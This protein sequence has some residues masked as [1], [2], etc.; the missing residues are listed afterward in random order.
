M[1]VTLLTGATL[2]ETLVSVHTSCPSL[3]A[4]T[5]HFHDRARG[6]PR[7]MFSAWGPFWPWVMSNVTFSPS[8]SSR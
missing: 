6:Q 4:G 8:T 5:P 7:M 1:G 2:F 3:P